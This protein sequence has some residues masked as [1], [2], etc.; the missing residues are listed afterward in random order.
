MSLTAQDRRLLTMLA[1]GKRDKEI[2][3]ELGVPSYWV[4]NHI[5]SVMRKIEA[6][7]RPRAVAMMLREEI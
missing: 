7:T 3:R 4:R 5:S 2:G 1:E 6:K